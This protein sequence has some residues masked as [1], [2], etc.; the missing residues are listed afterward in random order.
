MAG[1][2]SGSATIQDV[3]E[4]AGVTA[5]TV[6]RALRRPDKVAD[7]TC[8]RI[9]KA[10]DELDYIPNLS[11]GSLASRVSRI[12]GIIVP[13]M[14]HSIFA[15]TLQV[16]TQAFEAEGYRALIACNSYS[17]EREEALV[18]TLLSHRP[19]ALVVTGHTHTEKTR[20]MLTA[21]AIP[22]VEMWNLGSRP[23]GMMVGIDN[24]RAS[25]CMTRHLLEDGRR[26]IALVV[27][28]AANND[29]SQARIR[30]FRSALAE[31]GLDAE[32]APV[33]ETQIDY[34]AGAH[35]VLEVLQRNPRTDAIF[36]ASDILATGGL[37]RLTQDGVEIPEN[38]AVAGF[39][40]AE[41]SR[42]VR[43]ALT[44]IRMDRARI[45]ETAARLILAQLRGEAI[46]ERVVDVGFQLVR[47][48]SA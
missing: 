21:A 26:N 19:D 42:L 17:L 23:I 2:S 28:H 29:R 46:D 30:G 5:M 35:A 10:I 16:M 37:L 3:A 48:E 18:R 14:S 41:L 4:R 43:P 24:E 20:R 31:F 7:D 6:S 44:T 47:R 1:R 13:S 32:A 36:L 11:A 12:V 34:G 38:I 40:D 27:S 22:I 33:V 45:G 9:R 25:N 15:E 8:A 39:D